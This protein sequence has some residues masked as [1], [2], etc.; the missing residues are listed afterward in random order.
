MKFLE[1]RMN[2]RSKRLISAILAGILAIQTGVLVGVGAAPASA[3]A[4]ASIYYNYG[5]NI[6]HL[7]SATDSQGATPVDSG[8]TSGMGIATDGQYLYFSVQ[9]AGGN[10]IV[11][12]D[13]NY[14]NQV[15]LVDSTGATV[16][17][18]AYSITI[19]NGVLYWISRSSGIYSMSATPGQSSTL[20]Q[21]AAPSTN[22]APNFNNSMFGITVLGGYVY[23]DQNFATL[24]RVSISGGAVTAGASNTTISAGGGGMTGI[25]TDGTDLLVGRDMG[26]IYRVSTA[27]WNATTWSSVYAIPGSMNG[28]SQLTTYGGSIYFTSFDGKIGKMSLTGTG[29]QT[30]ITNT[31]SEAYGIAVAVPPAT[32]NFDANGGSGTLASQTSASAAALT[33]NAGSITRSGYTFAGWNT[34]ANGT[35]T[36]YADAAN[37]PFAAS[38]TLYAQWLAVPKSYLIQYEPQGG[39]GAAVSSYNEGGTARLA[40]TPTRDGFNFEGWFYA[41]EGGQALPTQFSPVG[42]K[43]FTLYAHW[44]PTKESQ[45]AAEYKATLLGA[46]VAPLR[47]TVGNPLYLPAPVRA[48]FTFDGWFREVIGGVA[49]PHVLVQSQPG[50]YT[51][52]SHWTPVKPKATKPTKK[53]K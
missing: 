36:A 3:T 41:K 8:I 39:S 16:I 10:S 28:V 32:V 25:A 29:A 42:A 20:A 40:Y 18:S 22:G 50:D 47:G 1:H 17:P 52:Y 30:W 38:T 11:R 15:V 31:G 34:A 14:Q 21:I 5:W 26:G 12:T 45:A 43:D 24:Y 19:S 48:G 27:A 13:L 44:S 23:F 35:G 2:T 53:R 49:V 46:D 7:R 51:L 4:T 9:S 6:N 37:F 33:A